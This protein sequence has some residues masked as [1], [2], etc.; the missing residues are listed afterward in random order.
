MNGKFIVCEG[1]D[2][3]GKT[4]SIRE[5]MKY[6][7]QDYAVLYSKGLK[8]DTP[9]GKISKIMPCT[10]TLLSEIF[11]LDKTF[12]RK[13]LD[14]GY[15]ILQDRW[16]Y[17]V[18]CHNEA[19]QKDKFL[20]SIFVPHLVQ[21]DY[22]VYFT[23]SLEERIARLKAT[24]NGNE[25]IYRQEM[26]ISRDNRYREFYDSFPMHKAII[27]TTGKSVEQSGFELYNSINTY[28]KQQN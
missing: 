25:L 9:A 21:P 2:R 15:L 8:S 5:A 1:L 16:Y 7:E 4:T 19:N 6:L 3:A 26:I 23:V 20:E 22:F 28:L 14:N 24:E 10:F 11:Y 27:D 12:V 17:S 13:N 18:M